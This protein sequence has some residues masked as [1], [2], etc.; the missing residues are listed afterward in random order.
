VIGVWG[1]LDELKKNTGFVLRG[2]PP[3]SVKLVGTDGGESSTVQ[4]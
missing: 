1:S 3:L 2:V 4:V